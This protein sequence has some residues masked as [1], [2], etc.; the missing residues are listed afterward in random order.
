MNGGFDMLAH[1]WQW[2]MKKQTEI[3]NEKSL[4]SFN[5]EDVDEDV[6]FYEIF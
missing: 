5:S 6:N 4:V 3:Q 1:T 2:E